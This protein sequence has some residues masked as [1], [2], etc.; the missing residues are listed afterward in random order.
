[1]LRVSPN[2]GAIVAPK[3]IAQP[4]PE[5]SP[6]P[7]IAGARTWSLP[8]EGFPELPEL[9]NCFY[10]RYRGLPRDLSLNSLERCLQSMGYPCTHVSKPHDPDDPYLHGLSFVYDGKPCNLGIRTTCSAGIYKKINVWFYCSYDIKDAIN[11][12]I[13]Y[14]LD[15]HDKDIVEGFLYLRSRQRNDR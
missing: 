14:I 4:E 12:R 3:T 10:T 9:T 1:M 7:T 11:N 13:L 15:L 8:A 6:A 2:N 5:E